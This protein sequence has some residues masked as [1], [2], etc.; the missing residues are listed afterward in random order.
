MATFLR[1]VNNFEEEIKLYIKK[2]FHSSLSFENS[3]ILTKSFEK[4]PISP[5]MRDFINESRDDMLKQ[6]IKEVSIKCLVFLIPK[7]NNYKH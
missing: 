1:D 3:Y 2:M 7:I 6:F 5:G 4:I